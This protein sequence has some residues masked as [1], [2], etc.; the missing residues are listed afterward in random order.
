M[1]ILEKQLSFYFNKD[2]ENSVIRVDRAFL[3]LYGLFMFLKKSSSRTKVLFTS[4]TC[5]S[6]V[7]ACIYAGL[8]PV[9]TDISPE[10][11][12][13]CENDTNKIISENADSILALV[14]IYSFGITSDYVLNLKPLLNKLGIILIEDVAQAIGSETRGVKTGLIGDYSVFSFGYSKHIDAGCGGFV[15]DNIKSDFRNNYQEIISTVT[16]SDPDKVLSEDYSKSFYTIRSSAVNDETKYQQFLNF[17]KK[18]RNLYFIKLNPD[19]DLIEKKTSNFFANRQRFERNRVAKYYYNELNKL[20]IP[21]GVYFPEI[22]DDYSIY[23]YTFL[24]VDET[25]SAVLSSKLRAF[26]INCSNLY[27]PVSRFFNINGFKNAVDFAKRCINLWVEPD[28]AV[29][30]YL[31]ETISVIR[32]H[33]IN[34]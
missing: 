3:G 2:V 23:R 1:S 21:E 28:I 7:Y 22:I 24:S 14:Y 31:K 27:I 34:K 25:D 30:N 32:A 4:N 11:F 19:W 33:Y 6:P 9:F 16:L 5:A 15:F 13:M 8:E 18:Y 10:D 20:K 29:D 17:Y 26:G 12:L